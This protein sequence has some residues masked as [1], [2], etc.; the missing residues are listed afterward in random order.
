M[1]KK[2]IPFAMELLGDILNNATLSEEAIKR[3][4]NVILREM[5]EISKM[6]EEVVFVLCFIFFS[7]HTLIFSSRETFT[8]RNSFFF[9]K[10]NY[11]CFYLRLS[12][13]IC[14]RLH[15]K[16]LV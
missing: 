5:E 12:L 11:S 16:E 14:T 6:T 4:R 2:D 15:S 8:K 9:L 1:L 13:T 7:W 10:L 3:E